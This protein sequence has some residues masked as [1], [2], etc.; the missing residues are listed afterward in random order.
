MA[1]TQRFLSKLAK[2]HPELYPEFNSESFTRKDATLPAKYNTIW[3][4]CEMAMQIYQDW[5]PYVEHYFVLEQFFTDPARY[6]IQVY[7]FFNIPYTE[8]KI[9]KLVKKYTERP[10][11]RHH[12]TKT[13]KLVNYTSL[14]KQH[15]EHIE[16]FFDIN[17]PDLKS[18]FF[19]VEQYA[20]KKPMESPIP[21][22]S[23]SIDV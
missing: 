22:S 7:D 6:I 14:S 11:Q 23:L 18:Y 15:L 9:Q 4:E 16:R 20:N 5:K 17:Y 12:I 21:P 3:E 19:Y 10:V 13:K 2:N 8:S 1:S